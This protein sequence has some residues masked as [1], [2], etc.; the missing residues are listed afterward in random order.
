MRQPLNFVYWL[1]VGVVL[2]GSAPAFAGNPHS[3]PGLDPSALTGLAA[4]GYMGFQF[5]K[6]FKLPGKKGD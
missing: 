2:I 1:V 4:A 5:V 6:G 3:T